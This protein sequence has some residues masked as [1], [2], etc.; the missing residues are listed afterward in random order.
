MNDPDIEESMFNVLKD[1]N[2]TSKTTHIITKEG[3][4]AIKNFKKEKINDDKRFIFNVKWI[5]ENS[6]KQEYELN[7]KIDEL[8]EQVKKFMS[9]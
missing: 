6:T 4:I 3:N 2:K 1:S 8:V 5:K 9:K 7:K